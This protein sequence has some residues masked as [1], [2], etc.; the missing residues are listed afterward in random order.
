[1][2]WEGVGRR[3]IRSLPGKVLAGIASLTLLD[4][5]LTA[6]AD[7]TGQF[8]LTPDDLGA[9]RAERALPGIRRLNPNVKVSADLAPWAAKPAEFFREFDI[10]CMTLGSPADMAA[11]NDACR[12]HGVKF[13]AGRGFGYFGFVFVDFLHHV[14]VE[15]TKAAPAPH[16]EPVTVKETH[17]EDFVPLRAVLTA[18]YN[19]LNARRT[20][21]V[22]FHL[23]A[24]H[25]FA[26]AHP[27]RALQVRPPTSH[28]FCVFLS[29]ASPATRRSLLALVR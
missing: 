13:C 23:L 17:A 4:D 14:F 28:A 11:V 15:E 5:G 26:Q 27:G 25:A 18:A 7:L 9:P 22:F 10:V 8:L 12:A 21:P 16:Q 20:S 2:L 6:A 3:L 24:W 1:M 29:L 19:K